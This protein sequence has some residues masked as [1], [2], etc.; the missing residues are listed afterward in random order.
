MIAEKRLYRYPLQLILAVYIAT[1]IAVACSSP[2]TED[3]LIK[4]EALMKQQ[5]DSSLSILKGID[6]TR[7]GS[8][9]ERARYALLMSQA[10]D[11]NYIDTTTFDV[12]QPAIDYY[13]DKGSADEKLKTCYY[14]GRIY[15]NQGNL[16]DAMRCFINSREY[17]SEAADTLAIANLLVAQATILYQTYKFNDFVRDNLDAANLY[18]K[19]GKTDY[20]LMSLCN[21]IDVYI[22]NNDKHQADSVFKVVDRIISDYPELSTIIAPYRIGYAMQFGNDDEIRDILRYFDSSDSIESYDRI[23]MAAA[24]L[25]IGDTAK[26]VQYINSISPVSKFPAALKYSAVKA[27]ILEKSGDLKGAMEAYKDFY[28]ALDSIHYSI[29]SSDLLFAQQQHDIEIKNLDEMQKKNLV[30]WICICALLVLATAVSVIYYHFKLIKSRNLLKEQDIQRLRLEKEQQKLIEDNLRLRLSEIESE[31]DTLKRLIQSN[32][33]VTA[34]VSDAIKARIE[35]LNGLLAEKISRNEA[36]GKP[37]KEWVEKHT[38]DRKAF[39]DSTRLAFTA[40][41]PKF[42]EYLEAH[43]LT[44]AEINYVCLYAIGLRGKEVG[45][46]IQLKRHYNISSEIRRKLGIDEHQTNIGIYVRKL[47]KVL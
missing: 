22:I 2:E 30:I 13:L 19:I 1:C 42:I 6:C 12:L 39:M 21:A 45:E 47:M 31:C 28:T 11:K 38:S 35:M 23:D 37:Y 33:E 10:L 18:S 46:Y 15:Q 27:E 43:N 3:R 26:A 5:P 24:Y 36:Y 20:Q 32:D 17:G 14:Q 9:K 8:D 34:Q 41:H 29:F 4:A 16:D 7:L 25:K 44:E 40:S